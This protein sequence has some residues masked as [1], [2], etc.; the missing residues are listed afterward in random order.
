MELQTIFNMSIQ[1]LVR[2][3]QPSLN[4]EVCAYRGECGKCAVGY[5]ISDSEYNLKLENYAAN[6][7]R[8][9]TGLE[10][11]LGSLDHNA[12]NL[13]YSL[14]MLHDIE[15][16][17]FHQDRENYDGTNLLHRIKG[18]AKEY[19]LIVPRVAIDYV[20]TQVSH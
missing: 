2:Q 10:A 13:M 11:T 3:D 4:G 5:F 20:Q 7:V 14:Q 17:N 19:G 16:S 6:Q 8:V 9:I 12:L 1:H 15:Y 18:I